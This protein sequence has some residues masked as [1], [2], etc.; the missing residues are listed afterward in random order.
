MATTVLDLHEIDSISSEDLLHIIDVTRSNEDSKVDIGTLTTYLNTALSIPQTIA[1][2]NGLQAALDGKSNVG[3]THTIQE[4]VGLSSALDVKLDSSQANITGR[5]IN[6][7]GTAITVPDEITGVK[8]DR[9]PDTV[10][11]GEYLQF[12]AADGGINN[13]SGDTLKTNLALDLVNNTSDANKPISTATQIGLDLKVDTSV[14]NTGQAAQDTNITTNAVAITTN[15]A[16]IALN[17]AKNSYPSLDANKLAGIET[18]ADVTDTANTWSSLG[19]SGLGSTEL[20]LTQR[21]VFLAPAGGG[22]TGGEADSVIRQPGGTTIA[23]IKFWSGTQAQYNALA[24]T[25]QIASDILYNITDT[26]FEEAVSVIGTANQV[27]VVTVDGVATV[28][29]DSFITSS[30]LSNNTKVGVT[31]ATVE[32]AIGV[33]ATGNV[34]NFYNEQGVFTTVTSGVSDYDDLTNAPIIRRATVEDVKLDGTRSNVQE[35]LV[36]TNEMSTITMRN[37]FDSSPTQYTSTFTSPNSQLVPA[38]TLPG[39]SQGTQFSLTEADGTLHR[40]GYITNGNYRYL[41]AGLTGTVRKGTAQASTTATTTGS[42]TIAD[43]GTN[44]T[45]TLAGDETGT[46][47]AGDFISRSTLVAQAFRGLFIETV[48]FN[49]TNTVLTGTG[50]GGTI[51]NTTHTI[52]RSGPADTIQ[53]TIPTFSGTPDTGGLVYS[54]SIPATAFTT[55]GVD[56]SS[57]LMQIANAYAAL[58]T[59][60]TT[61]GVVTDNGDG[62]SSIVVDQGT[63]TNIDSL[64]AITGGLNNANSIINTDGMIGD[65]SPATTVT[66]IDPSGTEVA[67][68]TASVSS[69]TDNN[70]DFIGTMIASIVNN[71]TETPIDFVAEWDLGTTTD[72][73]T[74]QRAGATNLWSITFNNN[75]ATTTNAGNLSIGSQI[76]TFNVINEIDI[77]TLVPDGPIVF[78]DGTI[79]TTAPAASADSVVRQPGGFT[80]DPIKFWS[81]TKAQYETLSGAGQVVSDILYSITDTEMATG[82]DGLSIT[83]TVNLNLLEGTTVLSTVVLPSSGGTT[84]I[85]GTANEIINTVSGDTNTLSLDTAITSAI[86]ANT[87]KTGITTAQAAAITSN[88]GKTGITVEQSNAIIANT[89]KTGITTAQATAITDNTAKNSY[90][91]ADS[92]KL[93]GIE[94]LADVTLNSISAGTDITISSTG[95]IAATGGGAADSVVRQP[96][97]STTDPVKFWTGTQA[98]YNALTRANDVFYNIT[99][100]AT[101]VVISSVLG[102][103]NEVDVGIVGG[104]AT[105]SLN[106]TITDAI[107]ANTAKVTYPTAD[108]TK[109]AGIETAA[110]VTDTD[111]VVGSLTAGDNITISAAG[112]IAATSGGGSADA[113]EFMVTSYGFESDLSGVASVNNF[114]SYTSTHSGT[115]NG[116]MRFYTNGALADNAF[117]TGGA[118]L[119]ASTVAGTITLPTIDSNGN[120]IPAYTA[121]QSLVITNP[122]GDVFTANLASEVTTGLPTDFPTDLSPWRTSTTEVSAG[123]PADVV[124]DIFSTETVAVANQVFN[125]GALIYYLTEGYQKTSAGTLTT[126][127]T[128]AE[129]PT[130]DTAN[131]WTTTTAA[132][133]GTSTTVLGTAGEIDVTTVGSTATASLNTAITGAITTNTAKTGITT[134]Q[135]TAITDNTAKTGITTAQASAIT[136]NTSK[137]GITTA[138][139][140]AITANTAKVTYT[141][142]LPLNNTF[143]GNNTFTQGIARETGGSTTNGIKFWSGTE[144]Q[145]NTLGTGRD[146]DTV[147]Y[148]TD[149]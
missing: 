15:A 69:S 120:A 43:Q 74:A 142:L 130:V 81:G 107:D 52:Y 124:G 144:A 146:Q 134:A 138:Q 67:S 24:A 38:I 105:V 80:V 88:T 21:G 32:S 45:L 136:A 58:E 34:N 55:T 61:D 93:A 87:A 59:A 83:D 111:N 118:S 19:I 2:V 5:I 54:S 100:T 22:G 9:I 137:I 104:T 36:G 128:A 70:I 86:T 26:P 33:S 37:D 108:S 112:V 110:D 121:G 29:L 73:L 4:I 131:D 72:R 85:A 94:A 96:S 90:P 39:G 84:I 60:I 25:N 103:N 49:G 139:S 47:A 129:I 99:D 116:F 42:F 53:G 145:Y 75:G 101:T 149:V 125:Q 126:V 14:Y 77:L 106:T 51:F 122:A 148:L 40:F 64:F 44:Q 62:T 140:N 89:A 16:A 30:I 27:D 113:I 97:G 133:G 141:D 115:L 143:T 13:I 119:R 3:H 78:G 11:I 46:F 132:G 63:E 65:L 48:V 117:Y 50:G 18:G 66:V 127:G 68:F 28:S 6:I 56:T 31:K 10:I 147:Y 71:N 82:A 76:Q 7:K 79:Q 98:Q 92:T 114:D 1:S 20:F 91:T 17:T 12:D 95:V 102:T 135:A 109:L 123:F 41:D 8:D 57:H 35:R 23:P